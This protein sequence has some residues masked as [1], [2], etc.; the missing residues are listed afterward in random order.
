MFPASKTFVQAPAK[1]DRRP[2]GRP[3]CAETLSILKC[4]SESPKPA[5]EVAN[6][7][8]LANRAV[9]RSL[10]RLVS[11]D[12]VFVLE[13]RR[14]EGASRPLAVY[15]LTCFSVVQAPAKLLRPDNSRALSMGHK[16][17]TP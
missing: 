8:G 6:A 10:S 14:F 17:I 16:W 1:A 11:R 12:F 3:L 4:L 2:V 13:R 9:V 7:L 5:R 15:W